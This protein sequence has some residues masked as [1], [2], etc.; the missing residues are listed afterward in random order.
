MIVP[1]TVIITDDVRAGTCPW[2]ELI[3]Q[4]RDNRGRCWNGLARSSVLSGLTKV[5][6]DAL[7]GESQRGILGDIWEHTWHHDGI[8]YFPCLPC[9]VI[10]FQWK[11]FPFV[12]MWSKQPF[13]ALTGVYIVMVDNKFN[14]AK[15][16]EINVA[17]IHCRSYFGI[18][19][20]TFIHSSI[21]LFYRLMYIQTSWQIVLL[22]LV[23]RLNH[24]HLSKHCSLSIKQ[25]DWLL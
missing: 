8:I 19:L 2:W 20:L 9:K 15:S 10:H 13:P 6:D 5:A 7:R 3:P 12:R 24:L 22:T 25:I 16:L 23:E 21:H 1:R 14:H 18:M 17:E 4:F 11:S